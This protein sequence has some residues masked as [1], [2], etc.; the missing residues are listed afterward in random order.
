MNAL[1]AAKEL[2][3]FLSA[4]KYYIVSLFDVVLINIPGKLGIDLRRLVYKRRFKSCGYGLIVKAGVHIEGFKFIEIG[5][6][7]QIDEGCIISTSSVLQGD[8]VYKG[9]CEDEEISSLVRLEDNTHLAHYCV[10]MGHGGVRLGK[11][12]VMSSGSKVYSLSSL[13]YNPYDRSEKV[14]LRPYD[15]SYFLCGPIVIGDNTWLGI[16]A[17]AMPGTRLGNDCFVVS[18]T[19]VK[20]SYGENCTIGGSPAKVLRRRFQ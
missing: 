2:T 6:N 13:E 10:I 5:N 15:G 3:S 11:G 18:N 19:L 7:V 8:V 4:W 20:E 1:S 17:I 16:N 12:A 14:R 9:I